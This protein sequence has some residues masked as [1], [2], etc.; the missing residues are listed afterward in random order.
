MKTSE[1]EPNF[2]LIDPVEKKPFTL[3]RSMRRD[4]RRSKDREQVINPEK[5]VEKERIV[6]YFVVLD[7][8]A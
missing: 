1:K 5:A 3:L 7:S 8:E 6:S 4:E 2:P